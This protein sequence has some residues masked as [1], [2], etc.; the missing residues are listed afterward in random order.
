MKGA[1][2]GSDTGYGSHGGP[3]P[4]NNAL[5]SDCV[6][7]KKWRGDLVLLQSAL[8]VVG[9]PLCPFCYNFLLHSP[10]VSEFY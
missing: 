2:H 9:L 5:P 10:S 8:V 6:L 1:K 7:D 4:R 3:R